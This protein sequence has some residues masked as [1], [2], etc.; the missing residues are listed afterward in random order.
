MALTEDLEVLR[1]TP[2]FASLPDEALRLLAFGADKQRIF[3]GETLFR[4]DEEA[5]CA[6]VIVSGEVEILSQSGDNEPVSMG[7]YSRASLIGELALIAP[8]ERQFSVKALNEVSLIQ[9]DREVFQRLMRE[10]PQ[11]AELLQQRIKQNLENLTE[12]LAQLGDSF[13]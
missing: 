9:V 13:R 5:N 8:Q 12:K 4:Q 6:Y 1:K 3:A 2:L 10:Y 11:L 7:K